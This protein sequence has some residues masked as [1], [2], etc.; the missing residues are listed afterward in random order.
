MWAVIQAA[1]RQGGGGADSGAIG[2]DDN[3]AGRRLGTDPRLPKTLAGRPLGVPSA[4]AAAL[5]RGLGALV[6]QN[7]DACQQIRRESSRF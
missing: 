6:S 7:L 5:P 3:A 4:G 1:V 2:D